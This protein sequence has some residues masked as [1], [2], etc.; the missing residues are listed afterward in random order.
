MLLSVI[1]PVYNTSATL[2]DA[3][4]SV[5]EQRFSNFELILINDGSSDS[6]PEICDL[7]AKTDER[8]KVVH[9]KNKGLSAARNQGIKAASGEFYAFIDS[10]DRFDE[11]AFLNFYEARVQHEDMTMYVMNFDKVYGGISVPKKR[12]KNS[13]ITEPKE[14]IKLIFSSSGVAFYT[15]NK[16]Y[17]HSLFQSVSFPEGKIFEDIVTTYK[18][19]KLSSKTIVTTTVGYHYIR[20]SNTIVS[21][22]FSPEYYDIL[23]ETEQLYALVKNDFP[24]LKHVA[25]QKLI[26]SI[27]SVGYKLSQAS[28]SPD[29]V[30]FQ[31][32]LQQDIQ[33]YQNEI[34]NDKKIPLYY[35]IGLKLLKSDIS[36]YK[37][38]YKATL[39]KNIIGKQSE[40]E[41]KFL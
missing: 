41:D 19:A 33:L 35:K 36:S 8:I 29:T 6:S 14:L 30:A 34:D 27:I 11:E 4:K 32:R 26:E 9:Q 40:S 13:I 10:D 39:K 22:T 38:Y 16:I 3:V 31:K 23:T 21:S 18:L 37:D 24:E 1:M 20:G 25:L 5:L 2:G 28:E 17:R 15:W 7:L 12:S